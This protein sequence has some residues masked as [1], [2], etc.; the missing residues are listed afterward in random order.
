ME[1]TIRSLFDK[2][3][4]ERP[5]AVMMEY[6]ADGERK[7]ITFAETEATVRKLA[8]VFDV[9]GIDPRKRPVALILENCPEWIET[10]LALAGTAIPVVPMDPKLRAAEVSYILKDSE[11]CAVVTDLAH[12]QLLETVLPDLP[13]VQTVFIRQSIG[14]KEVPEKIAGRTCIALETRIGVDAERALSDE[15]RYARITPNEDDV[16]ALI[17]TSGTTGF[18]KGAQITHGNF[19]SDALGSIELIPH[20]TSLDRFLVVLPLFHAFSFTA[21]FMICLTVHSRMQFVRSLRT[22]GEDMK[23]FQPTTLM[24]VPLLVEKFAAKIDNA[25]RT[26]RALL[27]LQSLHLRGLVKHLIVKSLGGRLKLVITGGAPCGTEVIA[28]MRQFGIP[29]IEGYGLT[30]ASPIVTINP[31]EKSKIGTIGKKIPNVEI[32]IDNPNEQ[33]VGELCVKGPIVMKGYLNRPEDTAEALQDGWLH[34]GDLASMDDEGY[35][36]IRGRKKALIVNR[37]G[38]NIYPEEVELCIG[39]DKRLLDI[40]VLG[41][42]DGQEVGEKVGAIIVPNV[43]AFTN[44]DGTQKSEEEIAAEVRTSVQTQCGDLATYKHPRLVDV[45]FEPLKRTAAMKIQ[46]KPYQ[47]TLDRP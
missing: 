18:P 10:Y 24:A 47:G 13:A 8:E 16:S 3:V 43:E 30:E 29:V 20:F 27:F 17:Y 42:H 32:R 41:Y 44:S 22:V 28:T 11:T 45:R 31:V 39:R 19:V 23:I 25:L 15:G 1:N 4:T 38:K 5:N 21:N 2:A 40:L 33:G 12:I 6:L 34:T 36:T 14:D 9:S 35:V 7:T 46:R 37:E 26:N